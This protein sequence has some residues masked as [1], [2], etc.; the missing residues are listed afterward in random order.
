MA[1]HHNF[2]GRFGLWILNQRTCKIHYQKY[3]TSSLK[4]KFQSFYLKFFKD[5]SGCKTQYRVSRTIWPRSV[6]ARW[7]AA[8]SVWEVGI[9]NILYSFKFVFIRSTETYMKE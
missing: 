8:A 5:D 2:A 3:S 6:W 4:W 9:S 1:D 7:I